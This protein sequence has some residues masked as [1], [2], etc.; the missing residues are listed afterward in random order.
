[1]EEASKKIDKKLSFA[2][3]TLFVDVASGLK[4]KL[5]CK[6]CFKMFVCL[7]ILVPQF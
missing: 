2:F 7:A 4:N 5:F 3:A 6:L 1:M